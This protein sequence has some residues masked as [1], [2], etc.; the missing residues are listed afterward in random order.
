MIAFISASSSLV[1]LSMVTMA[2]EGN[3]T[4]DGLFSFGTFEDDYWT[5]AA[6]SIFVVM[7]VL[8]GLLGAVFNKINTVL[9]QY[10]MKHVRTFRQ[11]MK[12][13][14][15][16]GLVITAVALM[17]MFIIDDCIPESGKDSEVVIRLQ[18]GEGSEH[19]AASIWFATPER[20]LQVTGII[21]M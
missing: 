1:A 21:A 15:F 16:G 7:G 19:A 2:I 4:F 13:V 12:H 20:V 8:G 10:R 17:S 14:M 11:G 18:C 5:I 9:T 3:F 6:L